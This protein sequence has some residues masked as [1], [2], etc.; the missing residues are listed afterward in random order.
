MIIKLLMD[1]KQLHIMFSVNK[2][3]NQFLKFNQWMLRMIK[4]SKCYIEICSSLFNPLL[5]P[6]QKTDDKHVALMKAN[7]LVNLYFDE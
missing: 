3:H 5:D 4:I 1:E 2:Q 6:I 7:L